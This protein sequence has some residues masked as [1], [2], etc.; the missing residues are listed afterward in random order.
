MCNGTFWNRTR[1]AGRKYL[2]GGFSMT[3]QAFPRNPKL[4]SNMQ[5]NV[6]IMRN[7]DNFTRKH[8]GQKWLDSKDKLAIKR[9]GRNLEHL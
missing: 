8:W 6:P 7:F 9:T 5:S 4:F 1:N 2:D 3:L